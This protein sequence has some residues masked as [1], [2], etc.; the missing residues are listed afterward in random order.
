VLERE[1]E[2]LQHDDPEHAG[3]AGDHE[4]LLAAPPER[5]PERKARADVEDEIHRGRRDE[6]AASARELVQ[7]ELDAE[8]EE[9]EDQP[10]R[11]EQLEV[12]GVGEQHQARCVGSDED[13][14][15]HE[16]RDRG[17]ADAPSEPGEQAREEEREAE[18][19]EFASRRLTR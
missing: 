16:E 12:L 10:E 15:E 8:V 13:P 5:E 7:R 17:Q 1:E 9:Q 2:V 11:R 6:P 14:G 18:R 3:D 19:N 4:G